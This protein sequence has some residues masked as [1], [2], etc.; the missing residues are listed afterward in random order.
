MQKC[1]KCNAKSVYCPFGCFPKYGRNLGCCVCFLASFGWNYFVLGQDTKLVKTCV[2][3]C[4]RQ[5]STQSSQSVGSQWFFPSFI[6]TFTF[7][8]LAS[9]IPHFSFHLHV[10]NLYVAFNA[11][12]R[13]FGRSL[14]CSIRKYFPDSTHSPTHH[15]ENGTVW[16]QSLAASNCRTGMGYF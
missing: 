11:T 16:L 6:F 1:Q 8:G 14:E 7:E 3:T 2:C 13:T 4:V 5:P 9:L 15:M 12:R 10:A